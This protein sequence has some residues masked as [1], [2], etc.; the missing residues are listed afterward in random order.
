MRALL[1]VLFLLPS[2]TLASQCTPPPAPKCS[3]EELGRLER[4]YA[5]AYADKSSN[6]GF[7]SSTWLHEESAAI[8]L[9]KQQIEEHEQLSISY[10][11]CLASEKSSIERKAKEEACQAQEKEGEI[12]EYSSANKRCELSCKVGYRKK[13]DACV[14][15][16]ASTKEP[17]PIPVY[18]AFVGV[19]KAPEAPKADIAVPIVVEEET[20]VIE[21]PIVSASETVE[22]PKPWWYWFNPLNWF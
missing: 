22:L 13:D 9:C 6:E 1:L 12:R 5:A 2:I 11:N 21:A 18:E 10:N 16:R 7:K 3:M 4:E 20:P 19:Q 14:D 17:A 15:S 8:D